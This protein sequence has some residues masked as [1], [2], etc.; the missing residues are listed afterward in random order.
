[1]ILSAV[2]GTLLGMLAGYRGSWVDEAIMRFADV[3]LGIP[4]LVL[5][6]MVVLTLGGGA[7]MSALAIA[8]TNWP[9]YARL[10]R[11]EVLRVKTLEF[12]LAAQSYGAQAHL[13]LGP[14]HLP[15]HSTDSA[16]PGIAPVRRSDPGCRD[17]GIHRAGRQTAVAGGA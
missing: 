13:I 15:S 11:S 16:Y 14:P 5:V 7:E 12:V 2:A 8:A 6:I 1:M 3:F 4:P 17:A 10:M 9:R